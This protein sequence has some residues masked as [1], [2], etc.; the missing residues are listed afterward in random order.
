MPLLRTPRKLKSGWYFYGQSLF[1][2]KWIQYNTKCQ[3]VRIGEKVVA[4]VEAFCSTSYDRAKQLLAE[5]GKQKSDDGIEVVLNGLRAELQQGRD[6]LNA[7]GTESLKDLLPGYMEAKS[8][9][10]GE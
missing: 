10:W 2:D 4:A 8:E 6:P 7:A 5:L 9:D 1:N 3:T